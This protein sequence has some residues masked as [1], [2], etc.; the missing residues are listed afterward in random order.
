MENDEL[1]TAQEDIILD[2]K[3]ELIQEQQEEKANSWFSD[4]L[5]DNI[6]DLKSDYIDDNHEDFMNYCKEIFK[7]E[8]C[9]ND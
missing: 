3:R 4:W 1:T 8:V 2:E 5:E 6:S 9:V 7:N